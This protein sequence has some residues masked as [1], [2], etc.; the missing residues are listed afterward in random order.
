MKKPNNIE[1]V[2]QQMLSGQRPQECDACW[3]LEDAGI[4]SDRMIKN[5]SLD[6]YTDIDISM[7]YE[8]ALYSKSKEIRMLKV[9]TSN[10]CNSA[11]LTCG[12][13]AS[14]H[15]RSL[16]DK[17]NVSNQGKSW[18]IPLSDIEKSIDLS[19]LEM[20]TFRGGE[21][22]L[23]QTNFE[24]L[25]KLHG[26]K[27]HK[28]FISFVTNGSIR[29]NK[30]MTNIL[31]KFN[32]VNFCFSID[33]IGSVFEYMRYPLSWK[34]C[35]DNVAWAKDTGFDVSVSYTLS[36][37]NIWYHDE[38]V[39]WFNKNNIPYIVNPVYSPNHFALNNLP[40]NAKEK[41]LNIFPELA[42]YFTPTL[43][44]NKDWAETKQAI[45]LQDSWKKIS[46]NDFMP[47]TVKILDEC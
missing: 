1:N 34:T 46:I 32:N 6:F 18:T 13:D 33:G 22:F 19:S 15:W 25:D 24:I 4:K 11:C 47:R 9:D 26:L 12:P 5:E 38:T 35:E 45:N 37:I 7:W 14:T 29:P 21:P 39:S 2:R 16:L 27:N 23:S 44:D 40:K 20:I 3:K 36:N 41:A 10:K 42:K 28:C 17:N 30:R 43:E 31:K 8:N